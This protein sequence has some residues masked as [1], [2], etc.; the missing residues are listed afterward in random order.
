MVCCYLCVAWRLSTADVAVVAAVSVCVE[1][2][3]VLRNI[4]RVRYPINVLCQLCVMLSVAECGYRCCGYI[5][6]VTV[7]SVAVE[8]AGWK[9]DLSFFFQLCIS[10]VGHSSRL[11]QPCVACPFQS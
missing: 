3:A 4:Q 9:S 1:R 11:Q 2:C 6:R 8:W 7:V 10:D 5:F